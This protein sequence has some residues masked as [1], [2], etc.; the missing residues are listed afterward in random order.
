MS[1]SDSA[2]FQLHK[3]RK[4]YILLTNEFGPKSSFLYPVRHRVSVVRPERPV[5]PERDP[6]FIEE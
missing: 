2:P 6:L 1:D 4:Y 5:L 3:G